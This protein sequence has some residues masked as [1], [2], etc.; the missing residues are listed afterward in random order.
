MNIKMKIEGAY[1]VFGSTPLLVK[2][3][4]LFS[5]EGLSRQ[6]IYAKTG[7]LVAVK[8]ISLDIIEGERLV[9]MGLSGSG[10]SSFLRCLNGLH[11]LSEGFLSVDGEKVSE[12]KERELLSLRRKKFGMVFQHFGLLPHRTVEGN[13]AYG[14][15]LQKV[16]KSLRKERVKETVELVGLS[17]YEKMYVGELS[18]GMQ[19]RVGIARAL[20]ID[21]D[22][23]LMDEAF[24][25]L[26]P[27][28][29]VEMQK[30]LLYLQIK[31]KKT[32][33]FVTHD[34]EEAIRLG[35]RIAI[36]Q[37]GSIIQI[38]TPKE[39]LL[40]PANDFIKEFISG[41]DPYDYVSIKDIISL[42]SLIEKPNNK[43]ID[44]FFDWNLSINEAIKL[45]LTEDFLCL[46]ERENILGYLSRENLALILEEE[47]KG[48]KKTSSLA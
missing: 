35:N 31:L 7:C 23:L 21:P 18:G 45:F 26:D 6:D 12:L 30:E 2:K 36:M 22:I 8:D 9:L 13:I 25:A 41:I 47:R 19:Q 43:N 1:K 33:V 14:L 24:S 16:E 40:Q 44:R 48:A 37:E 5:K 32:L 46:K 17:G 39:I 3:A 34:I 15:E 29:R 42:N 4:L 20:A 11:S 10:K 28:L 27:L 38:G